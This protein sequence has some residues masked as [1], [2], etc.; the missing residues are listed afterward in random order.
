MFAKTGENVF[1]R[2]DRRSDL[3]KWYG[4]LVNA[5]F[6]H[7]PRIASEHQKTPPE[8]VKMGKYV[9]YLNYFAL[10]LFF[11]ENYHFLHQL[12]SQLKLP[13][14]DN[15]RKEAKQRYQDALNAYVTQYFG[16]PLEKLNVSN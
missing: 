14:L 15:Q 2:S 6:E 10:K 7:V 3:D 8:V 5:M 1:K 16:R 9:T 11:T 12:L 13:G 4:A